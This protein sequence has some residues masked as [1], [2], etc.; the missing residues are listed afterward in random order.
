[1]I[2]AFLSCYISISKNKYKSLF[3]PDFPFL[4]TI[5]IF[6]TVYHKPFKSFF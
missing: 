6:Y 5:S 2:S 3:T 1:M 4:V